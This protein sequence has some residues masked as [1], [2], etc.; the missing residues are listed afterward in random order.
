VAIDFS[1]R[2]VLFDLP[3]ETASVRWGFAMALAA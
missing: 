1:T 3:P 2:K